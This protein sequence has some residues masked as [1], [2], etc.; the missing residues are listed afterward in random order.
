MQKIDAKAIEGLTFPTHHAPQSIVKATLGP[1]PDGWTAADCDAPVASL[2]HSGNVVTVEAGLQVAY[3]D[4]GNVYPSEV[5][6]APQSVDISA[7]ADGTHYVYADIAEDGAFSGFGHTDVAPE[8]GVE[9][10]G[11]GDLYN[12]T[13]VTHYNTSD[14]PIRRVYLGWVE[15]VSGAITDVHCYSLGSSVT[16]P[17]NDGGLVAKNTTVVEDLPYIFSKNAN[18]KAQIF[19]E[20]F[21]G[22]TGWQYASGGYGTRSSIKSNAV[23]TYTGG[24]GLAGTQST[25]GSDFPGNITTPCRVRVTVDRGY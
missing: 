25:A 6:A 1:R 21:W 3:A 7:A 16:V 17:V 4:G 10:I 11:A 9:R 18:A 2:S 20:G 12:P 14:A 15:K 8:V 13:T 22:I 24:L 23:Y 19:A 5:L